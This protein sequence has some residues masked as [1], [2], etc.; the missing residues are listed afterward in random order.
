MAFSY[1]SLPEYLLKKVHKLIMGS[2]RFC[3]GNFGFRIYC[4]DILN[5]FNMLNSRQFLYK[6][7]LNVIHKILLTRKPKLIYDMIVA[8]RRTCKDFRL[9]IPPESS[10][11]RKINYLPRL[12]QFYNSLPSK[13]KP[14]D[15]KKMRKEICKSLRACPAWD[16]LGGF[17]SQYGV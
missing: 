16:W 4:Q 6:C 13:L 10:F 5:E 15:G 14:L 3:R 7:G 1:V 17:P 2:A 8:P 9:I 12:L 11:I